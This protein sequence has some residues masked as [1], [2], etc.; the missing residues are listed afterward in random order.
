MLELKWQDTSDLNRLA[1][2]MGRLNS[3][4]RQLVLQRAVNH[5]GTIA[6]NAVKQALVKQTG[7]SPRTIEKALKVRRASGAFLD[8]SSG[9]AI[10]INGGNLVYAITTSGGDI[11]LKYFRKRETAQGVVATV[12]GKQK[13]YMGSFLKGGRFP[14]RKPA[15]SLGGHV[16]ERTGN[17]IRA[18]KGKREG[19]KVSEIRL[20]DSGVII[21]AEMLKGASAE[22]F[23]RT[24]NER[25]PNRVTHELNR[26]CPGIFL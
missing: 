4:E 16:Y 12:F 10:A 6:K 3:G 7:L 5:T 17:I 20:V 9:E 1:N 22:A 25:L 15:K 26:L 19:K 21:P 23:Q 2:A 14:N 13:L 24:V 8:K 18:T 11:S